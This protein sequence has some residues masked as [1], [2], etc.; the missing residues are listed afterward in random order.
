MAGGPG[1]G[2]WLIAQELYDRGDPGFVDALRQVDDADALGSFAARWVADSRPEARGFLLDYLG[3]PLNAYRHEA[4]VKRAFKR[5]EAAGDD[6][7]MAA[8][9][10]AFDRS[11][12]RV[13]K[14]RWHY[15]SDVVDSQE[16]ATALA[17]SWAQ[18]GLQS[19]G[20]WKNWRGK[21]HVYGRW[22]EPGA[23]I[24]AGTAMPRGAPTIAFDPAWKRYTVPDWVVR[25]KLDPVKFAKAAKIPEARR[26]DLQQWRLFSLATRGYL[27]RRA[28]RYF[29]RLGRN[30]P[31]RYIPAVRDALLRYRDE[32]AASG[33]ALLDN[34]GL[35]HI[36]FH[37][38]P[39]IVAGERGWWLAADHSLAD[40]A[41][42]PIHAKLWAAA[43]RAVVD[44][45]VG[46]QCRAVRAWAV[47]MI[48]RDPPAFLPSFPLDER[49]G[50]LGDD[51]PAVAALA[52]DLI[53][54]DPGLAAIPAGRWLD[55]LESCAPAGLE[56]LCGIVESLVD[57][58]RVGLA[59]A[60]RLAAMRPL[61]L[62][63]LGLGW[64]RT[65]ALRD[66]DE[67]R[68]VLGLAEAQCESIRPEILAWAREALA[69][70]PA[71]QPGWIIEFLDSRLADVRAAGWSWFLAEPRVRGDVEAWRRLMESPYDDVRLG[72]VAELEARTADGDDPAIE[73]GNLDAERLRTLW[74]SVLL[75]VERGYRAKPLVVRQLL[76]RAQAR[77]DDLPRLL[78]LLAVAL[79]SVRG[80][81][82]RSGLAAVVR[83]ADRDASARA[84]VEQAFPELQLV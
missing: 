40:L 37:H 79:R 10:V 49:L 50:L 78:P 26:K 4:L 83:V 33:L 21:Y 65:K 39:A 62:A 3:R 24:P 67:C 81:E 53:R 68:S 64:L 22:S 63:R 58:A 69:G 76:R 75:N 1:S 31:A 11:A 66:E 51:D 84:L 70:S 36:L 14:D 71:F 34:W 23:A 61:P 17:A 38:S 44:V 77:P 12:R 74:A 54:G 80:P 73:R 8:F 41:P 72:L 55:L 45:L 27:R 25:L 42:A 16:A 29:R 13:A 47:G 7:L 56:T 20:I 82:F 2:D 57:P 32:D 9:L 15:E 5:A 28:W 19:V 48:R 59:E 18:Q 46:S 43:P 30:D 35:V 52:A 6:G 60:V